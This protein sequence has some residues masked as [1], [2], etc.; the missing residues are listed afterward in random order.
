MLAILYQ[1]SRVIDLDNDQAVLNYLSLFWTYVIVITFVNGIGLQ[2]AGMRENGWLKTY[3]LIAGSKLP[4]ILSSLLTP[5][6]ITCMSLF[7][8]NIIV[9]TY[10]KILLIDLILYSFLLIVFSLPFAIFTLINPFYV[11]HNICLSIMTETWNFPILIVLLVYI[12]AGLI[13]YR[14]INLISY[15]QR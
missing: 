2:L 8:F 7:L 12:L 6:L 5:F 15:V 9:G 10:M 1:R 4:I 3:V 14:K 13:T 11:I